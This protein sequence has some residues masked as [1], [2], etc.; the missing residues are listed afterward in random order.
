D[1]VN[2]SQVG[3]VK[4]HRLGRMADATRGLFCPLDID[5]GNN[6]LRALTRVGFSEAK[7]DT[8]RRT[9]DEGDLVFQSHGDTPGVAI[10]TQRCAFFSVSNKGCRSNRSNALPSGVNKCTSPGSKPRL[11]VSCARAVLPPPASA[12]I[13]PVALS[14]CT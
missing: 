7:S 10:R 6:D 5:I 2:L 3:H 8:A 12:T 14:F 4:F 1:L 9:G 11:A 13:R